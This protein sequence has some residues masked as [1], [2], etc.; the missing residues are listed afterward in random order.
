[1]ANRLYMG[2]ENILQSFFQAWWDTGASSLV[3][4]TAA[5]RTGSN[6]FAGDILERNSFKTIP[7]GP[8][9]EGFLGYGFLVRTATPL[10]APG[11]A[12]CRVI[13]YNGTGEAKVGLT[14][15]ANGAVKVYAG[16][17][18]AASL[19][20]SSSNGVIQAKG[21]AATGVDFQFVEIYVKTHASAGEVKVWVDDALVVNASGLNTNPSG[22]AQF[23]RF[24]MYIHGSTLLHDDLYFND[25]SG[26]APHN[27]RYTSAFRIY[28][29]IPNANGTRAGEWT[30]GGAIGANEYN[31]VDDTGNG[32]TDYLSAATVGQRATFGMGGGATLPAV[33]TVLGV[34]H[35][36]VMR[37]D[38]VAARQVSPMTVQGGTDYVS[39]AYSPGGT[40]AL[41]EDYQYTNPATSLPFTLSELTAPLDA[42]VK[43][44]T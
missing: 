1:M 11:A 28:G 33:G 26:G 29:R 22:T 30:K 34:K 8:F 10:S 4:S 3:L 39:G 21:A 43:V 36:I 40:Y 23:D 37:K 24:R 25:V 7:G 13:F 31:Q 20:A 41:F 16:A 6:A 2:C 18:T 32:D 44:T 9:T 38:D 14:Y 5:P 15:D 42:G 35:Q 12:N 17:T 27:T 19:L